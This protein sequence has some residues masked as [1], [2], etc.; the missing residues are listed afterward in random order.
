MENL[1]LFPM[2]QSI[3]SAE[4]LDSLEGVLPFGLSLSY[5]ELTELLACRLRVLRETGRVEFGEGILPML[6]RRF[7][8]S[9]YVDNQNF[10]AVLAE[11]QEAFYYFKN[12]CNDRFS[13]EDLLDFMLAVFNGKAAGSAELLCGIS[14]EQL[15]R[16]ARNDGYSRYDEEDLWGG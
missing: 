11:L 4:L 10:A 7:A 12:E 15:C 16:W 1:S 13:D 9:P 6:I 14:L 3:A 8:D 5:E 2:Q